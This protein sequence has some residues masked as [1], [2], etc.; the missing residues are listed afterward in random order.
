[1]LKLLPLTETSIYFEVGNNMDDEEHVR[2]CMSWHAIP[3]G[4]VY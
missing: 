2:W 1:M 4:A 3:G